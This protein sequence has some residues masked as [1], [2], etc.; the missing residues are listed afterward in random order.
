MNAH[1]TKSAADAFPIGTPAIN[2]S[3]RIGYIYK[4]ETPGEDG[5]LASYTIGAGGMTKTAA[6]L[7]FVWDNDTT[8]D[9]IPDG[10][11]APWL[12]AA[13]RSN[14][15]AMPDADYLAKRVEIAQQARAVALDER[16]QERAADLRK[17]EAFADTM[18]EIMPPLARAVLVAE[19]RQDESDLMTDYW[20]S[21]TLRRVVLAWSSHT[22]NLFPEMR[23]AAAL[24]EETAHLADAP[25][26]AEHRENYS[27]GG[28]NYL[29][30][31][32]R[33]STGWSVRKRVIY[34]E[35]DERFSRV[36]ADEVAPHLLAASKPAAAPAPADVASG[37]FTIEEHAHTKKG[38]TMFIVCTPGR[39]ERE[40]YLER[41]QRA[42]LGGGWYTRKYNDTPAGFAF[43]ERDKA[44]A[45]ASMTFGDDAPA[46]ASEAAAP[47]PAA[48]PV[49]RSEIMADKLEEIASAL[50]VMRD[51]KWRDRA[52][53]TPKQR[54]QAAV[55]RQDGNDIARAI[56]GAH[57]LAEIYRTTGDVPPTLADVR[58]RKRLLELAQERLDHSSA[59]YYDAGLPTGAPREESAAASDF[60]KLAGGKTLAEEKADQQA[61][62]VNKVRNQSIPGYFPTPLGVAEPM[63]DDLDLFPLARVLEPSAGS[64]ELADAVR[65]RE[66]RAVVTCCEVNGTLADICRLKGHN[67]THGDFM[68][69]D[70]RGTYDRVLM[71]PPFE[72]GQD[73]EHIRRAF[74]FLKPGGVLV[75]ITSPSWTFNA[76]RKFADFR[77]WFDSVDGEKTDIPA[78]A[79]KESGTNIATVRVVIR[80]AGE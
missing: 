16:A 77:E 60:W 38:F 78:G 42:R 40:I 14:V 53:R 70:L 74:D 23:K 66:P 52:Q 3:N 75:A 47:A 80:K 8:S 21:R 26:E 33:H 45:F 29:K 62:L 54:K 76:Q 20:G 44:E 13:A 17:A 72:R 65:E 64:G 41:L 11:A 5:A 28:G 10:I 58:S 46:P 71:N 48:L 43:R 49:G 19:Y 56:K 9:D 67:T 36:D 31:G 4:I 59:G 7:S 35:G 69:E 61:A 34:A 25:A 24:F 15:P 63:L 18:R 22:R 68:S 37:N 27:M 6:R 55:A 1:D 39:V 12:A 51:D 73:I 50:V 32:G 2:R 79:F 30:A 57:A